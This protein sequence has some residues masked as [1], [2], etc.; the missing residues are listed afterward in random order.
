MSDSNATP[1][2]FD[3][4]IRDITPG[5]GAQLIHN[6]NN[7]I[8]GLSE[9][10]HTGGAYLF[11]GLVYKPLDCRPFPNCEC[12][13]S[14]AEAVCLE[15]NADLPFFPHNW[16]VEERN[17]RHWLVR[18][19]ARI[20]GAAF[21]LDTISESTCLEME[22]AV[23][24]LNAR[25]W[26]VCDDIVLGVDADGQWFIVDLSNAHLFGNPNAADDSEEVLRFLGK[27]RPDL[28]RLRRDGRYIVQTL[29]TAWAESKKLDQTGADDLY[30]EYRQA[31][32]KPWV[33]VSFG[34]RINEKPGHCPDDV[35]L[36]HEPAPEPGESAPHTWVLC[37]HELPGDIVADLGLVLASFPW[38]QKG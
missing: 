35:Y 33:Y 25:G 12:C 6:G 1:I 9:G 8:N 31:L 34:K 32:G 14:T 16:H 13:Y 36:L 19:P 3:L 7:P 23:Q 28:A 5:D 29:F 18:Q 24:S 20:M 27:V 10:A 15:A 11:N 4:S 2:Q 26:G 17:G 38:K 30:Q 22:R 21:A 37:E